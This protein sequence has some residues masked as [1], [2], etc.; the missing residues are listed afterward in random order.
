M[1]TRLCQ[2]PAALCLFLTAVASVSHADPT[3]YSQPYSVGAYYTWASDTT[4]SGVEATGYDNFSLPAAA[5]VT[6]VQW[7]GNYIAPSNPAANPAAPDTTSFLIVFRADNA[8]QPGDVLSSTTVAMADCNAVSLGT[9]GFTD[10]ASTPVYQVP[11][12]GYRAVLPTPFAAAA[13]QTYWITI[14]GNCSQDEPFWSWYSG[15]SGDQASIQDFGGRID[16][17]L[18][19]N[20]VLEGTAPAA[21]ATPAVSAAAT[22]AKTT[23]GSGAPAVITLTLSAPAAAKL[24]VK[25]ALGGTGVNGTDYQ[26]LSGKVKFA[27]GQSSADVQIVGLGDLGGASK[28]TVLLTLQPSGKYTVGTTKPAKVKI[29]PNNVIVLP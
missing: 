21:N 3:V 26:T 23:V 8:G 10:K 15:S 2:T 24:T 4:P 18:D 19:R 9:I 11:F 7:H 13:G 28:K 5:N 22:V 27:A 6:A 25:Y 20:F 1:L 12:Y 16:R 14:V 17:P 29:L